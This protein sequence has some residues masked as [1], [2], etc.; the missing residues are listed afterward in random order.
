MCVVNEK[1]SAKLSCIFH[2]FMLLCRRCCKFILYSRTNLI[3]CDTRL[4]K[5]VKL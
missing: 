1:V 5:E 3:S 2:K 4:T